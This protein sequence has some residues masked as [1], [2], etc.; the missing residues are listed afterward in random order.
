MH[1]Q[2]EEIRK[3]ARSLVGAL[4]AKRDAKRLIDYGFAAATEESIVAIRDAQTSCSSLEVAIELAIVKEAA[5]LIDLYDRDPEQYPAGRTDVE[6]LAAARKAVLACYRR[7]KC[8]I[9]K[10]PALPCAKRHA[11]GKS[12][13]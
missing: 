2:R 8:T 7:D 5:D 3:A 9:C 1:E 10:G 4:A 6:A 11:Q 12:C 13:A